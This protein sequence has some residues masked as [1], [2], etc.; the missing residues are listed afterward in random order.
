MNNNIDNRVDT[1][2][3]GVEVHYKQNEPLT[4]KD[5]A[6][7]FQGVF[8]VT[9]DDG[10]IISLQTNNFLIVDK[11]QNEQILKIGNGQLPNRPR[12]FLVGGNNYT[13]WT[14]EGPNNIRLEKGTLMVTKD[15]S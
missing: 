4:F 11:N 15:N 12:P 9:A 13:L 10:T 6:L 2:S 1:F 3:Y 7:T 8:D 5:F 14:F